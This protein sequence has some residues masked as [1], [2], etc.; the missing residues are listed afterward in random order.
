[1]DMSNKAS[2]EHFLTQVERLIDW[3]RL[4]LLIA[5][6]AD[7]VHSDVPPTSVRMLLLARWYGMS[8]AALLDACQDRIS[9]RRFLGLSIDNGADDARLAE[10]FR[11]L[12]MQAP[13]EVQNLVH[14][15]EAQILARGFAIRPGMWAEAAVLQISADSLPELTDVAPEHPGAVVE[16][17]RL[18]ETAFFQPGELADLLKQGESALVRG[19]ARVATNPPYSTRSA[20]LTPVPEREMPPLQTVIEWPWGRIM[21]LTDPLKIGREH[22]FCP[23]ANE[24]QPYL[25]VSRKH[26]ELTPCPEGV[27]VRD[28]RSRNGTF[29]NDEELPKGQAFLV[30]SDAQ[31]RFGPHCVLQ[32]RLKRSN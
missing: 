16:D 17:N 19:G 7:R 25:H 18:L 6:I 21:D 27:W 28:L 1:M 8:E 29:V 9:F 31:V 26:A 2:P 15:V 30:D 22:R 11:R 24:L 4:D 5:A 20:E 14:A 12:A 13:V 32:L 3:P 10:S 23:F